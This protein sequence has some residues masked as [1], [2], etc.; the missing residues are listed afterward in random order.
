[1]RKTTSINYRNEAE[2]IAHCPLAAAMKVLGGRWKLMLLWYIAHEQNRYGKLRG[3][4]PHI[5]GKMLY[6]QLRELEEDGLV[7]RT[8]QGTAVEYSLTPLARGVEPA[9]AALADWSRTHGIPTR[10]KA[11]ARGT[12]ERSVT[13]ASVT[14][15]KARPGR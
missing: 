13:S 8:R 10:L 5:S 1:M 7:R 12:V 14:A 6:Q 4:I 15:P 2:L 9:L 11:R 3:I